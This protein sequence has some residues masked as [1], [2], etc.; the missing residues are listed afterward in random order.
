M[1]ENKNTPMSMAEL[2][3][4]GFQGGFPDTTV[5]LFSELAL[6]TLNYYN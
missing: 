5:P 4:G 6:N 3:K 1:A 2:S